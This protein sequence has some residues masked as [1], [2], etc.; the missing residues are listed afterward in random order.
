MYQQQYSMMWRTHTINRFLTIDEHL[1]R[2]A[3]LL[4]EGSASRDA[5]E[6]HL[7]LHKFRAANT[8]GKGRETYERLGALHGN[9]D[10]GVR[11]RLTE[12]VRRPSDTHSSGQPPSPREQAINDAAKA[13]HGLEEGNTPYANLAASFSS[14]GSPEGKAMQEHLDTQAKEADQKFHDAKVHHEATALIEAHRAGKSL[15]GHLDIEN[16]F[17]DGVA[18]RVGE[19]AAEV[20]PA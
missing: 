9:F 11:S 19:L 10:I 8:A 6:T 12:L 13:L 20:H 3:T 1:S 18:K 14:L 7:A 15:P 2:P 17:F 16:D 4:P 5:I